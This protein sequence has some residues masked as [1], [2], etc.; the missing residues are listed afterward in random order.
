M[1]FAL[2]LGLCVYVCVCVIAYSCHS[3]NMNSVVQSTY[4]LTFT[5]IFCL[6]NLRK[7]FIDCS[8]FCLQFSHLQLQ[9]SQ[10]LKI[11]VGGKEEF[12]I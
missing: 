3:V 10:Y 7:C 4:I 2:V 5:F 11:E 9:P 6:N 1:L 12:R 8:R